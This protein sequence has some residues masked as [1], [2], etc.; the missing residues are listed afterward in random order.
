MSNLLAIIQTRANSKRLRNKALIKIYG[1]P[2]IH[3]VVRKVKK[4]K[5]IKKVIVSTSKEKTDDLLK[6]LKEQK[7]DFYRGNLNN[8]ASRLINT[9]SK[10]KAKYFVRVNGDS[11]LID[12]RIIDKAINILKNQKLT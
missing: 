3:H 10:Y 4:S 6:Y 11:P 12:Y 9:A 5:K 1:L 8:V 2:M 7:I